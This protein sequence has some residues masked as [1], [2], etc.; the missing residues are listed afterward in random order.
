MR[1]LFLDQFSDLGGAQCCLL[2]LLPAILERGWTPRVA[3]P[4]PGLL[5]EK[6]RALR[7]P[8]EFTGFAPLHSGFKTLADAL[9]LGNNSLALARRLDWEAD[10]VYVNGPRLLPAVALAK[11]YA[12][13]VFHAHSHLTKGYVSRVAGWA[14]RRTRAGVIANCESVAKP[15]RKYAPVDVVFNGVEEHAVSAAPPSRPPRIGVIGRIAPEKGQLEFVRAARLLPECRFVIYGARLFSDPSY[16]ERVRAEAA[17]LP[18]E[19]AGW[20]DDM[21]AVVASL[22]LI[23]VPSSGLEATTRVI[24]EAFSAGKL[25]L[26]AAAGGIPEIV[27]DGVTGFLT[28]SNSPE[29][30]AAGIRRALSEL[31]GPVGANAR[32]AWEQHFRIGRFQH[33]VCRLLATKVR[34]RTAEINTNTAATTSVGG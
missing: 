9:R 10:L 19:F 8:V 1:I 5:A 23:V 14:I 20:R 16:E 34:N 11:P 3:L 22:D 28:P 26:A 15:L 17:G 13:V 18:V 2:D 12:P 27:E 21:R 30:L 24:L 6:L 4:G 25:V 29:E 32:H 31:P 7:I 33:D